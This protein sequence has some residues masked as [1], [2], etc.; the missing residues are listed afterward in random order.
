MGFF[1]SLH[2]AEEDILGPDYPYY[3]Q[4]KTPTDLGITA[5]GGFGELAGDI[6][7]L[8]EYIEV[9]VS[10]PSKASKTGQP[11]GNKFF[12]ETPS[13]CLDP[14]LQKKD[15]LKKLQNKI[16]SDTTDSSGSAADDDITDG[17]G[18][19]ADDNDNS[20]MVKRHIYINNVPQGNIPFIS[21]GINSDFSDFRGL[22]PGLMSNLNVL[23]PIAIFKSFTTGPT[24][25]CRPLTMQVIDADNNKTWETNH[26]LD[27]EIEEM[28][29]CDFIDENY[30]HFP[31][32]ISGVKCREAFQNMTPSKYP[33]LNN[34]S[35]MPSDVFVQIYYISLSLL[36][37]YLLLKLCQKSKR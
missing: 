31:N 29:P 25:A 11:L 37:L 7:G 9:L 33:S 5:D 10:G 24:P 14:V 6:A 1:D 16:T 15:K 20:G 2:S 27:E 30:D 3:D 12:I 34:L 32:P 35:Q 26:V 18:S 22:I 17:S 28:D 23:N 21:S 36:G 19:A 8:I 13:T 4:I